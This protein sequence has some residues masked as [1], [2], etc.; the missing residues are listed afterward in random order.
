[1]SQE[2]ITFLENFYTTNYRSLYLHAYSILRRRA[3]AEVAVQEA[4]LVACNNPEDFANKKNPIKWI[5]KVI[6]NIS[7][8]IYREERYAAK[9]FLSLEEL[10]PNQEPSR[11]DTYSFELIQLCQTV[12]TQEELGFFMR[13]AGGASTFYKEAERYGIQLAACYKRFER[14]RKKIQGLLDEHDKNKD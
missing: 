1:M 3:E 12:V 2:S 13:I 5:E 10:A 9:L 8:H 7:L 11:S 4:F 14:I 6:E